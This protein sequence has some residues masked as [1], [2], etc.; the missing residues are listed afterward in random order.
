MNLSFADE[1]VTILRPSV[2]KE[3]GQEVVDWENLVPHEVHNCVGY[4]LSG[5]ET[6][7]GQDVAAGTY[8]LFMPTNTDVRGT[9]LIGFQGKVWMIMGDPAKQT[10]PTGAVDHIV[11]TIKYWD[12]KK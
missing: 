6:I 10:S 1:T 8:V 12:G 9:D 11:I 2:I 3:W 7:Q 4:G 5:M